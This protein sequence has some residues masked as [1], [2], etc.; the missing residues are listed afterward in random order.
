MEQEVFFFIKYYIKSPGWFI[1][2]KE[3][4]M[5]SGKNTWPF[6][7]LTWGNIKDMVWSHGISHIE[8]DKAKLPKPSNE[9]K[10][11]KKMRPFWLECGHNLKKFW[12][13]KAGFN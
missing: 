8:T 1:L 4:S 2:R 10:K 9:K 13:H 12:T 7:P 3:R 5:L 11:K 6:R